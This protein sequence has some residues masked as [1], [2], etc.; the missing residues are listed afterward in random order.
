MFLRF[1]ST[2]HHIL[3][4]HALWTKEAQFLAL[5][6]HLKTGRNQ[7]SALPVWQIVV[8]FT[9]TMTVPVFTTI[10]LHAP[11]PPSATLLD[12]FLE[13]KGAF[14]EKRC[15]LKKFSSQGNF[16]SL[17]YKSIFSFFPLYIRIALS[18]CTDAVITLTI[19]GAFV[20]VSACYRKFQEVLAEKT[21]DSLVESEDFAVL[22]R[23]F[24]YSC[25]Y[26]ELINKAIGRLIPTYVLEMIFFYSV[27]LK[28]LTVLDGKC[29]TMQLWMG[30]I[31]A[32]ICSVIY[33][34]AEISRKVM[35]YS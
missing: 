20:N 16:S 22:L 6:K 2:L 4:V 19:L 31:F 28:E 21:R 29:F 9:V 17:N 26:L 1:T 5:L 18:F 27:Y 35:N 25:E 8:I 30:F 24:R 32:N 34:S 14:F 3:Y 12:L 10:F 7:T 13:L 11:A 15:N 33:I 23:E